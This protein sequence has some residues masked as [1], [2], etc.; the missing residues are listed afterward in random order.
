M[1]VR[2]QSFL[3]GDGEG[4]GAVEGAVGHVVE[5]YRLYFH[6]DVDTAGDYIIP[7]SFEILFYTPNTIAA[8]ILS[9]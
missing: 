4:R 7:F 8:E 3:E 9:F 6:L 2:K 1:G 5:L